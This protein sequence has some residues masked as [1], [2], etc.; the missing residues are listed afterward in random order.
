MQ[1]SELIIR[2][3]IKYSSNIYQAAPVLLRN[4][5]ISVAGYNEMYV[6]HC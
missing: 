4:L 3:F 1:H 6:T 2:I 5:N